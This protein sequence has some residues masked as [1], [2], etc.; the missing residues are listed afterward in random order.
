MM[1]S[2]YTSS[3]NALPS[4][5]PKR[6]ITSLSVPLNG[7]EAPSGLVLKHVTIGLGTQNY[8]CQDT[9]SAPVATGA[10][11]TLYDATSLLT[12]TPSRAPNLAALA[13]SVG[14]SLSLP[15]LGHH[16]FSAAGVPTFQLEGANPRALLSAKKAGSVP[17]PP[18]SVPNS[19]PW[20]YL[21]DD[22]RGVSHNLKA[23]YRVATAGGAA[24][25]TCTR[26]GPFTVKYVAE[27]WFYD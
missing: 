27:Y 23:V 12:N 5:F 24:P 22:G 3:I 18:N 4:I 13:Y 19:V 10:I 1:L 25:S 17:A 8:T 9:T 7:L 15:T 11:A 16:W 21:V 20:L 14:N 6:S 26:M 2:S